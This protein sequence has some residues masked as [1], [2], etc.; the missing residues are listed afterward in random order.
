MSHYSSHNDPCTMPNTNPRTHKYALPDRESRKRERERGREREGERERERDR[1]RG[2]EREGERERG[3]ESARE[4]ERKRERP[5]CHATVPCPPCCSKLEPL[6]EAAPRQE[7]CGAHSVQFWC[8]SRLAACSM[9]DAKAQKT[10]LQIL[11]LTNTSETAIGTPHPT[12]KAAR[13]H[14]DI[15]N[16]V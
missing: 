15:S 14:R 6:A 4:R 2:R 12:T 9:K 3:R 7:T 8:A 1:E 10:P 16:I 13:A 5:N 11:I